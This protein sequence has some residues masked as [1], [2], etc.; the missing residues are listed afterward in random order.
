[1]FQSVIAQPITSENM[2]FFLWPRWFM[3][4]FASNS[5]TWPSWFVRIC[6]VSEMDWPN[7][8]GLWPKWSP[9]GDDLVCGLHGCDPFCRRK[10]SPLGSLGRRC[11]KYLHP[12]G[13]RAIT[14]F[15]IP[16]IRHSGPRPIYPER[17]TCIIAHITKPLIF[18]ITKSEIR[19]LLQL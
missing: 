10:R 8:R 16:V 7:W 9:F 11:G 17:K 3:A 2:F 13:I 1:M 15:G 5:S 4:E 19:R 14:A 6:F 18:Q 12:F